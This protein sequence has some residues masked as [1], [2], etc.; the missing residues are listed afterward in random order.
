MKYADIIANL[1]DTSVLGE[2]HRVSQ[3]FERDGNIEGMFTKTYDR[4]D[5]IA[6]AKSADEL[7]KLGK[8]LAEVAK[9]RRSE[10]FKDDRDYKIKKKKD[11]VGNANV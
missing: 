4:Y 1:F 11:A 7:K 10:E 9:Y 5:P 3:F 6:A 2:K 8:Y